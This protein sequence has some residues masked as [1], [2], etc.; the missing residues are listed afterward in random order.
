MIQK[1]ASTYE[2]DRAARANG[3]I[4]M[5]QDGLYKALNGET[6]IEEVLST[7]GEEEE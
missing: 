2:L 4:S 5:F 6:T 1:G 7:I 3:M